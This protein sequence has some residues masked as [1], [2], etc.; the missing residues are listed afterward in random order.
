MH[1]LSASDNVPLGG[2]RAPH[3]KPSL[4]IGNT[5]KIPLENHK[6]INTHTPRVSMIQESN[7]HHSRQL[8][9]PTTTHGTHTQRRGV[10]FTVLKPSKSL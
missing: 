2:T 8:T 6:Q 4:K 9:S 7:S 1:Q 10:C 3:I 5:C